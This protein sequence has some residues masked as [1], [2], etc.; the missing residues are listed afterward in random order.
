MKIMIKK[1][2]VKYEMIQKKKK[3]KK[4]KKYIEMQNLLIK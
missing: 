4:I 3:K 1:E 2:E